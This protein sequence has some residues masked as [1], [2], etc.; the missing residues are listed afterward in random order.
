MKLVAM[1][2]REITAEWKP[3]SHPYDSAYNWVDATTD[4]FVHDTARTLSIV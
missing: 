1:H 3:Q 2:P 4:A